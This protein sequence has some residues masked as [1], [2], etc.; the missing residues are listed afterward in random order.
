MDIFPNPFPFG[1]T[2]GIVDAFT[3]GLPGVCKTGREVFERID[4]AM[5]MRAYMPAG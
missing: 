5:F 4:G 3:A 1:N 2:N